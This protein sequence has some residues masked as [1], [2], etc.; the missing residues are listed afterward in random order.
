MVWITF[1]D[2]S[3]SCFEIACFTLNSPFYT[4]KIA[5]MK[6]FMDYCYLFAIILL[7]KYCNRNEY[8]IIYSEFIILCISRPVGGVDLFIYLIF[9]CILENIDITKDL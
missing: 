2:F 3:E 4:N 8:I 1:A 6:Y 9:L 7:G 5:T